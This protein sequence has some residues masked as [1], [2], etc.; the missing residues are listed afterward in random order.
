MKY[1]VEMG[2]GSIIYVP[3]FVEFGLGFQKLLRGCTYRHTAR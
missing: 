3:G 1:A 2:S